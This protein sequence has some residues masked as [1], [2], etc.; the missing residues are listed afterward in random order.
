MVAKFN[1]HVYNYN[2]KIR[3]AFYMLKA[4]ENAAELAPGAQLGFKW[5]GNYEDNEVIFCHTIVALMKVCATVKLSTLIPNSWEHLGATPLP[6]HSKFMATSWGNPTSISSHIL[7]A[8]PGATHFH[9]IPHSYGNTWGNPLPSHPT[10]SWQHLGA[11]HFHLQRK[12][13]LKWMFMYYGK[14]WYGQF[15]LGNSLSLE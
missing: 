13:Q 7:M 8:T 5:E 10:F 6:S 15:H 12:K 3:A 2:T 11:T 9:L 4:G 14:G 1:G